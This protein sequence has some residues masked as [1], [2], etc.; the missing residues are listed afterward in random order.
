MSN[1]IIIIIKI[2]LYLINKNEWIRDRK[3]FK[4]NKNNIY[5]KK[6]KKN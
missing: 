6:R 1:T 3:K 5:S 4:V 2:I